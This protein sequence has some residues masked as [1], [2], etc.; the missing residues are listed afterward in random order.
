M[1]LGKEPV[2]VKSVLPPMIDPYGFYLKKVTI[3]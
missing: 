1:I 3:Q 2:K